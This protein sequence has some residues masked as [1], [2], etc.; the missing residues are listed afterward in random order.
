MKNSLFLETFVATGKIDE[1][2]DSIEL[3][4]SCGNEKIFTSFHHNLSRKKPH[5]VVLLKGLLY[6]DIHKDNF[7]DFLLYLT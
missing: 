1:F 7:K 6:I 4:H 3:G 5:E 2:K